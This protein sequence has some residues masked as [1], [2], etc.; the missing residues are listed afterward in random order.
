MPRPA[1]LPSRPASRGT[2]GHRRG[3]GRRTALAVAG[4]ALLLAGCAAPAEDG[5]AAGPTPTGQ[6]A[7]AGPGAE[8][9]ATPGLSPTPGPPASTTAEAPAPH[10]TVTI[11]DGQVD[12]P[13]GRAEVPVG[14]TF[15]LQVTSDVADE[16]HL[17]GVD[18]VVQLV[19]GEPATVEFTA[20]EPGL[21]EVETHDTGLLL[22][23]LV[24]R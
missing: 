24:V 6:G 3:P 2:G 7:P 11:T 19:P 4:V 20:D 23:Q 1:P 17:H 18:D 10:L 13:P 5:T 8:Q 16:L 9:T 12:P 22:T 14:E 21:Y 15:R